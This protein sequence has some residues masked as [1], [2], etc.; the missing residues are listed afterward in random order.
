M[1]TQTVCETVY[2]PPQGTP[3]STH[4]T[5]WSRYSR[6]TRWLLPARDL[7]GGGYFVV[8]MVRFLQSSGL[9]SKDLLTR[10]T[11]RCCSFYCRLLLCCWQGPLVNE[12]LLLLGMTC[13]CEINHFTQRNSISVGAELCTFMH[14]VMRVN[15]FWARGGCV[16]HADICKCSRS[17]RV[18][19][20][21]YQLKQ[22]FSLTPV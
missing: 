3:R 6:W 16:F 1:Q 10:C 11:C 9:T 13:M 8:G 20:C 4:W 12:K 17:V 19:C 21:F 22:H 7:E 18:F 15:T 2:L 5:F 14:S